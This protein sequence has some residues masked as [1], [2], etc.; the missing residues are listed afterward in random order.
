VIILGVMV[1]LSG[2]LRFWQ[3][4][5]LA[6]AAEAL[7]SLVRNT[8]TVQRRPSPGVAPAQEVAMTELVAG[9]IV[10]LQVGT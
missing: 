5:P 4:P 3:V 6:K 7:K 8:A 10:H 2:L 1:G 9:D